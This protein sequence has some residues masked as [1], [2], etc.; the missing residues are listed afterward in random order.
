MLD[1]VL[2][3]NTYRQS[4]QKCIELLTAV[5]N[6]IQCCYHEGNTNRN[7]TNRQTRLNNSLVIA[8]ALVTLLTIQ[9]EK[10]ADDRNHRES[11]QASSLTKTTRGLA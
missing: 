1:S 3:N 2:T 9:I 4:R 5:T 11:S 6:Y 10:L 7:D 8:G